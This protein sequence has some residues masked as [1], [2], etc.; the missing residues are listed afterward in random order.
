MPKF[1]NLAGSTLADFL[2]SFDLRDEE[3]VIWQV[4][5]QQYQDRLVQLA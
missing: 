1:Y 4:G 3:L 5:R 2:L